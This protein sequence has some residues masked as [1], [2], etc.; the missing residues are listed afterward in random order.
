LYQK[1][2]DLLEHVPIRPEVSIPMHRRR[3]GNNP[4]VSGLPQQLEMIWRLITNGIFKFMYYF[5][6]EVKPSDV[7]GTKEDQVNYGR[8]P[9]RRQIPQVEDAIKLLDEASS[10]YN[11]ADSLFLLGELYFVSSYYGFYRI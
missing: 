2:L 5:S 1:A 3:R 6:D 11:H 8:T 7:E 10:R 4:G 9:E